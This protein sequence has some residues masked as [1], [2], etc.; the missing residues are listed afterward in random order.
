MKS[1]ALKALILTAVLPLAAASSAF[2]ASTA[3]R[4][5]HSGLLVWAFLGFCAL[6]V[7]AQLVPALLVMFGI[8]KAVASPK[9]TAA[10]KHH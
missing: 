7:V 6:I 3:G 8:V 10:V 5:D 9:E 4:A 1:S 2:A